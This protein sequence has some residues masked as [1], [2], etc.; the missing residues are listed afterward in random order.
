MIEKAIEALLTGGSA[1]AILGA[2]LVLLGY[3]YYK[4]QGKHDAERAAHLETIKATLPAL[5]SNTTSNNEVAKALE[6]VSAAVR[7]Q[8]D[9][10]YALLQ[11]NGMQPRRTRTEA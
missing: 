11:Q 2:I 9:N 8:D 7:A 6:K 1:S 4:L 10:V 3:A 5:A